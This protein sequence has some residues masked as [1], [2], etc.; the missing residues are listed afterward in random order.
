[1]N[2]KLIQMLEKD[3]SIFKKDIQEAFQK[4]FEDEFGPSDEMV[5]PEKDIDQSLSAKGSIA[6][7]AMF[8]GEMVGGAIVEI[9]EVTQHNHLVFLYVKSGTQGKGIGKSIWLEI[10]KMHPNTKVWETCT[11]YFE[12]RNI[13]FYVNICGFVITEY[14]NEKHPM[15]NV[16]DDFIGDGN[17]GMFLFKKQM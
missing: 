5:L 7:K 1:M 10:E 4:G 9:N 17:K 15:Q 8:D 16:P 3:L 12:K 2:F 14:F 13:H 6:Y 11:P